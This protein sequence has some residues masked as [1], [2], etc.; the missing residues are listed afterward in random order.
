MPEKKYRKKR[1]VKEQEQLQKARPA[2][3][4]TE[5]GAEPNKRRTHG[6]EQRRVQPNR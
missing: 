4:V 2:G 5:G 1:K 6:S 3:R